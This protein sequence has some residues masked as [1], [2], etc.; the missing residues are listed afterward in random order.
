MKL[1]EYNENN[2]DAFKR[3]LMSSNPLSSVLNFFINVFWAIFK[4]IKKLL[5]KDK[6]EQAVKVETK[7][8]M[9]L[10]KL[11]DF[12]NFNYDEN[13]ETVVFVDLLAE[14]SDSSGA[15]DYAKR[16]IEN[17]ERDYQVI[18][19]GYKRFSD[20]FYVVSKGSK[21]YVDDIELLFV[22]H[23]VKKLCIN[24]LVFNT[25][26]E[27]FIDKI[28]DL[29]GRYDFLTEYVF[30]D[31]LSLCPSYFLITKEGNPCDMKNCTECLYNNPYRTV[32]I[33]DIE[34][35][36]DRFRKLFRIIDE[37]VFFSK[38]SYDMVT[39]VYPEIVER[40]KIIPH[41]PLLSDSCSKYIRPKD[42]G[43]ITVGFVG[44]FH[45]IKGSDL[46]IETIDELRSR[47]L[48]IRPVVIGY[49]EE[50]SYKSLDYKFTGRYKRD[51]LGKLLSENKVDLVIYPSLNSETYSYIVQELMLLNVPLVVLRRG[52]PAERIENKYKLGVIAEEIN[53]KCVA[54]ATVKLL[55]V[56]G[57]E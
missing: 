16:K 37:F 2:I 36:R 11:S 38:F 42:D 50:E 46:F 53:C 35:Y 47:D 31:Y 22:N 3:L 43:L 25:D 23:N 51:D 48:K 1:S 10:F 44:F 18:C 49:K 39:R 32:V 40:S 33:N 45:H 52:A 27:S 14:G 57:N 19:L 12:Y 9:P 8:D 6:I 34:T 28:V 17:L 20:Q 26:A 5:G 29:R 55:E 15:L 21:I 54:D 30:H 4:G 56:I 24:N 7:V 13:K 41:E